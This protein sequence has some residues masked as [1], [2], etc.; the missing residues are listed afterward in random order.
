FKLRAK[1]EL[2]ETDFKVAAIIGVGAA[3]AL[4]LDPA[5]GAAKALNGGCAFID[6]RISEMGARV[7]LPPGEDLDLPVAGAGAYEALRLELGLPDGSR[8]MDIDKSTLLECGFEE[9]NGVDFDKGCYMGQELTAR[10]K[11]RGLVKR[12]LFPVNID[13]PLPKPG[14]PIT[15]NGKDAGTIKSGSDMRAIALLRIEVMEQALASGT[16]LKSGDAVIVP[17]PPT[18]MTNTP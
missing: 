6:P 12:R 3:Q 14:T 10:T 15:V 11:H 18:W 7:I 8:D 9:L 4:G 16:P 17:A 5:P 1:V 13:G 2:S